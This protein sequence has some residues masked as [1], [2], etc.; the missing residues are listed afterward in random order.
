ML[1]KVL[2]VCGILSSLLYA[3]MIGAIQYA[4]YSSI[5]MILRSLKKRAGSMLVIM[6]PITI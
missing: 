5:A 2:L 6:I 4:G 1:R 3:A